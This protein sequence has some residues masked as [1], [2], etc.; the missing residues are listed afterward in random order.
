M[1]SLYKGS[2]GGAITDETHTVCV[3]ERYVDAENIL[4]ALQSLERRRRCGRKTKLVDKK[5]V[6]RMYWQRYSLSD[7]GKEVGVCS[8]TVANRLRLWGIDESTGRGKS[9]GRQAITG[10][11]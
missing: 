5:V 2:D 8:R 3:C 11:S 7:I 4:K 1:Y 6:L 10:Q 9:N